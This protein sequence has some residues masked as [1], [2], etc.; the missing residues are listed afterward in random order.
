MGAAGRALCERAYAWS[1]VVD[2]LEQ[3][4]ADVAVN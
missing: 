1:I 2:R 4:Y 3:V